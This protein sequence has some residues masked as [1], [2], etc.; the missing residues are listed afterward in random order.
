MSECPK[1][2]DNPHCEDGQVPAPGY[3][4]GE[5]CDADDCPECL[6]NECGMSEDE[7]CYI[8]VENNECALAQNL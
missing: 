3:D 4:G 6:G 1:R 8:C 5:C 7:H 2:C